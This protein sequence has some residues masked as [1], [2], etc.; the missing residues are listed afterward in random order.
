M[1]TEISIDKCR[2]L[3]GFE[4]SDLLSL[5]GIFGAHREL[6]FFDLAEQGLLKYRIFFSEDHILA[7]EITSPKIKIL[8]VEI[9]TSD[10]IYIDYSWL[11]NNYKGGDWGFKR[12]I[13]QVEAAQHFNFKKITLWAYGNYSTF[14]DWA[15]Y[16]IWG[17]YGFTMYRKDEIS[18]FNEQMK[19]DKLLHC[20]DINILVSTKEGTALWKYIGIDWRV[21]FLF[22]RNAR[23]GRFPVKMVRLPKLP[24]VYSMG[25]NDKGGSLKIPDKAVRILQHLRAV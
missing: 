6:E 23:L 21:L 17:K 25:K 3:T 11:D 14:P 16:I 8:K 20:K 13:K 2:T 19:I 1:E 24:A 18:K 10:E 9:R 7:V 4:Y 12:L 5:T 15:G 22:C